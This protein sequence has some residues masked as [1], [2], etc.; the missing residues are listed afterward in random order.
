MSQENVEVVRTLVEAFNAGDWDRYFD[1]LDPDVERWDRG[2]E[3][4]ATV[5]RGHEASAPF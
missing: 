4:H 2:D 3:P 1:Q 5:H